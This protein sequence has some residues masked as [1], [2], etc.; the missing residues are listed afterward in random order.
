LPLLI[1]ESAMV[2]D[3][4]SQHC[5]PVALAVLIAITSLQAAAQDPKSGAGTIGPVTFLC[6]D[7]SQIEATFDNAPD[8]ATVELVRGEQTFTLPQAMS[9]SGARYVGDDIEFWTK[10]DDAMVEWQGTKLECS[11]AQ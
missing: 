3:E 9:G 6:D 1:D 11:T 5:A 2:G 8:P 4:M 10:G 7:S